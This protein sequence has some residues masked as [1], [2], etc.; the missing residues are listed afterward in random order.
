MKNLE[1]SQDAPLNEADSESQTFGCR[2]TNPE[3]CGSNR[4][5][6]VCAFVT[7]DSLCRKPP[8]SWKRI[9]ATLKERGG[10]NG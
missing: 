4:L 6:G 10:K 2:H 3:I 1:F 7:G 9:Y 5:E 8:R